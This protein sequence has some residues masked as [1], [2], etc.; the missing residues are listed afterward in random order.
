MKIQLIKVPKQ[1]LP[2]SILLCIF[3]SASMANN[4]DSLIIS[5]FTY[6]YNQQFGEADSLLSE[7]YKELDPFYAEFLEIDLYWW[8]YSTSRSWADARNFISLL[9]KYEMNETG[10]ETDE[11]KRLIRKSYLMRFERK[12]YNLWNVVVLRTEINQMLSELNRD[13]LA[14]NE[15]QLKLFDMF[16]ILFKYFENINPFLIR[17]RDQEHKNH[18]REL[19]EYAEDDNFI[20]STT[21]HYF[22]GRIYQKVEKEPENAKLHFEVLTRKF[23][24]NKLFE[25]YL[26]ESN[27]KI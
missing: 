18:L 25:E 3:H 19:N 10:R 26:E 2:I 24:G 9:D 15:D 6:T 13:K 23:P 17:T 22:L 12:R 21:A 7:N 1:I 5:V 27:R 20:I 14:I 4:R 8:K 16:I 11:I